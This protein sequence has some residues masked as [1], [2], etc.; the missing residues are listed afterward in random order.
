MAPSAG[1]RVAASNTIV[2]VLR[3]RVVGEEFD[4]QAVLDAAKGYARP[5]DLITRL[6]RSGSIVPVVPDIYVF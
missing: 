2:Q 5:R 4:H 3:E 1:E 6:S